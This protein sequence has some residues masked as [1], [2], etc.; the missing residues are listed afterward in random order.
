MRPQSALARVRRLASLWPEMLYNN[1]MTLL[2]Q[3]TTTPTRLSPAHQSDGF[4]IAL[5]GACIAHCLILP[6]VAV[7]LPAFSPVLDH[8]IA[9]E[10]V[11]WAFVALAIPTSWIA[12]K[13]ASQPLWLVGLIR[14]TAILGLVGLVAGASGWPSHSLETALT[15]LGALTIAAAHIVNVIT[16]AS[17]P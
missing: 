1:N 17:H 6:I 10:W 5:S 4:A 16:R 8:V 2:T 15:V 12:F 14:V 11:H 9:A 13:T 3:S 7:A